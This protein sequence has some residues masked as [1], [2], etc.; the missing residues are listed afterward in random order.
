MSEGHA[1]LFASTV[2][3]HKSSG[4]IGSN[5]DQPAGSQHSRAP[6][7]ADVA[8]APRNEQGQSTPI[9]EDGDGQ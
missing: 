8:R 4:T 6:S 9:G 3:G 1:N 5:G 7:G 2:P